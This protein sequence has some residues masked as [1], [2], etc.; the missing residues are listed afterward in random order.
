MGVLNAGIGGNGFGPSAL[1][2][3][4]L[5]VVDQPGVRTVIILLGINDI[6]QR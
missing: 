2:R 6:Q 4:Q 5:D 3:F 1:S